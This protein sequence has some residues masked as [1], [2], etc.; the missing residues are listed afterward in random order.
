MK[1]YAIVIFSVLLIIFFLFGT[2]YIYS[3]YDE[4]ENTSKLKLKAEEE[5]NYLSGTIITV[6]NKFNN[7]NYSNYRIVEQTITA[8]EEAEEENTE[9]KEKSSGGESNNGKSKENKEKE[10]TSMEMEYSS[11]LVNKDNNVDWDEIKKEIEKMYGVWPT[12]LIDLN[13]LNVNKENLLKY[14]KNLDT[15]TLDLEK[16]DKKSA[17]INFAKLYELLVLYVTDFLSNKNEIEI[18]N[19]KSNILNAYALVESNN[20]NEIRENVSK[21]RNLYGNYMNNIKN[22]NTDIIG[23]TNKIFVLLN[24]IEYSSIQKNKTTFYINYKNLMQELE[25]NKVKN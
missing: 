21:S 17:L 18:Y 8:K 23:K 3:G 4:K 20:W 9:G 10:I 6:M 22:Q 25:S 15:I 13:T 2:Y 24:E 14:S 12:I 19:V 11:I 16:K 7:I 1:K 5:I